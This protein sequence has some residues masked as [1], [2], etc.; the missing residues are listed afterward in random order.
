VAKFRTNHSKQEV[1]DP[2]GKGAFLSGK[3]N[4]YRLII[5]LVFILVVL[6]LLSQIKIDTWSTDQGQSNNGQDI[7]LSG[8]KIEGV[9][10]SYYPE[11]TTGEVVEHKY[12]TLS[13]SEEHEQA[14]WVAY[15]LTEDNLR[16]QRVKR[17]KKYN[18]DKSIEGTS[19]YHNDYTRSGYTRGHL[20]PAGDMAFNEDAMR[21]SFYMSNM[22]PQ[23]KEFNGGIWRELEET[24]RNWAYDNDELYI[25]SGPVLK[26]GHIIKQIGRNEVSVPDLFYKIVLDIKGSNKKAIAFLMPN[27]RSEKRIQEYI[28][29]I[30][31]LEELLGINFFADFLDPEL[32]EELEKS[33]TSKGWKF[34]NKKYKT[35]INKWNNF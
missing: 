17:A 19:A 3:M 30:D 29:S 33:R 32:E 4:F 6:Y 2:L 26:E 5:G 20:A 21:E 14:E 34:D 13:Y 18:P 23:L 16:K 10:K 27:E 9:V 28:V 24:V 15:K 12:Y 22:S 31:E 8:E 35:R 1:K 11:S 7:T 25:V